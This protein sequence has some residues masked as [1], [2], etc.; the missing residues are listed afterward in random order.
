MT[1]TLPQV[2][3]EHHERIIQAVDTLP[4]LGD[5]VLTA[6]PAEVHRDL[7]AMADFLTTTLL[8]HVDAAE[9]AL[10]PELERMFQNRHSMSPMRAE[11]REIKRLVGEFVKLAGRV[12]AS[13]SGVGVAFALRRV[14]FRLYALLEI[15]LAEEEAY[16][17]IVDH[18]VGAD[19]ADLLAAAIDHP[20]AA[21]G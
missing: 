13:H 19:V 18:G 12:D 10:Y 2:G 7:D 6:A 11:H 20:G 14:I 15:H 5:R 9:A 8:P 21:A 3:H 17:R 1:H 16:L 4:G